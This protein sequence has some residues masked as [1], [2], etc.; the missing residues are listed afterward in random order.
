MYL[1]DSKI[2]GTTLIENLN[3]L[4]YDRAQTVA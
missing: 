2:D 4:A 1:G 3:A